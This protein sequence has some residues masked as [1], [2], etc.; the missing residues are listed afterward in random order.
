MSDAEAI[1]RLEDATGT[2]FDWRDREGLHRQRS[3][4]SRR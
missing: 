1:R 3:A 2:E 4:R